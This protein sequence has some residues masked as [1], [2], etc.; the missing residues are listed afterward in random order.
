MQR[1]QDWI[2]AEASLDGFYVLRTS[3]PA[4]ELDAAGVITASKNLKYVER[5]FRHIKSDDLGLRPLSRRLE[6]HVKA[7]VLI[8]MLACYLTRHLRWAWTPLAFTDQ[9][10]AAPDNPVAAARRSAAAQ[11]KAP[12]QHDPA[13]QPYRIFH[14]L[15]EH[16]ARL[17][18]NQVR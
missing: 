14:G 17:T 15:L 7:H 16:L 1:Q 10:P 13:G 3:V 11:A 4:D 6:E 9:D 8:C 12:Y 2:G 5:D 18:R